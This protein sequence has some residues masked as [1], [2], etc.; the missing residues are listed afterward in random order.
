MHFSL[1]FINVL[2]PV[3]WFMDT[4]AASDPWNKSHLIIVPDLFNVLLDSVC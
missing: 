2:Y 3:G 4:E 1:Y